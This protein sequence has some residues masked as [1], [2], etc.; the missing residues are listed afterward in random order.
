MSQWRHS[1]FSRIFYYIRVIVQIKL[2]RLSVNLFH[3][4]EN[5]WLQTTSTNGT[6]DDCSVDMNNYEYIEYA[7]FSR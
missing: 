3:K 7:R 5:S 4:T 2:H 6:D 1:L